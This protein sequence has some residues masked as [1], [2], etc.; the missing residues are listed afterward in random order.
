MGD[1]T[2]L[3]PR[4]LP[5]ALPAIV[6]ALA[7]ASASPAAAQVRGYRLDPVHTRVLFAIDHAGFST[8]LGTVSGSHGV[9]AFDPDDWRS[10]RIDVRVPL[11]RVD[12]GVAD[13]TQAAQRMLGSASYPEARFISAAIEPVDATH[14]RACGTLYLHGRQ[15]PLCLDVTFNQA[16]RE[17]LPPFHHLA[18]FSATA[19]L[20]RSAF[21][22]DK[23]LGMVG[24]Q[25]EL[26][27]EVEAIQ[28]D[29]ALDG[30]PPPQA[31]VP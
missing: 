24:D 20:Q 14:A 6:L 30:L 29:D 19:T 25:V 8:A 5:G 13:W 7:A 27:I 22:I 11:L 26:R 10:A 15:Q 31:S 3:L 9:I 28:D 1:A 23:W 17:P 16:R 2:A 4:T 18:G 21:G 12:L